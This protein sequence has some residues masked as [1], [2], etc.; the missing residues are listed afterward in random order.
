VK[1]APSAYRHGITEVD[2]FHA[3]RNPFRVIPGDGWDMV[4][5][6]D[7]RGGMIEVG[8]RTGGDDDVIFHAMP[9]RSKFLR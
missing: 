5:G 7:S 2:I 1:I 8:V 6:T 3:L 9:A 4:I